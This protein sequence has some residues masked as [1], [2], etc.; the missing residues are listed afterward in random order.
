MARRTKAQLAKDRIEA[1]EMR[2]RMQLEQDE[3]KDLVSPCG[4]HPD[5]RVSVANGRA[6]PPLSECP[7]CKLEASGR[8]A[9]STEKAI[10]RDLTGESET[11]RHAYD[12][13]VT[14]HPEQEPIAGSGAEQ[15]A[16]KDMDRLRDEDLAREKEHRLGFRRGAKLAYSSRIEDGVLVGS[17][18]AP[19]RFKKAG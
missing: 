3:A 10:V 13:F 4:L 14:Q 15:D 19:R 12:R 9:T 8:R 5:W 16:L 2:R 6:T 1:A 18:E 17:Y 11:M 7:E